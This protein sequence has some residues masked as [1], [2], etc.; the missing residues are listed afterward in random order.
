MAEALELLAG[1]YALLCPTHVLLS[2]GGD[3]RL[4]VSPDTLTNRYFNFF[5]GVDDDEF[6]QRGSCT[7]S[8]PTAAS[9]AMAV[10]LRLRWLAEF[11]SHKTD[12]NSPIRNPYLNLVRS[13][14]NVLLRVETHCL[15]I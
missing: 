6:L 12:I 13:W 15:Q 5:Y 4:R 3:E 7:A 1:C 9:F 2:L 8:S 14:T 11:L 10:E